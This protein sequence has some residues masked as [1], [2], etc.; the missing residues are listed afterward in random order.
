MFE[1]MHPSSESDPRGSDTLAEVSDTEL[2]ARLRAGENAAFGELYRR[3]AGVVRRS[4]FR[5]VRDG[6]DADDLT[7][8]AFFRVLQ[9]V[10]RGNGPHEHARTYLLT[11]AR[12]ISWEWT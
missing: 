8:E 3:H 10:R 7:A 2:L 9:A 5:L 12:R 1:E 11:V 4:A 6:A